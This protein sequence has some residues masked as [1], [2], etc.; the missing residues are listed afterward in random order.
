M[1]TVVGVG[2]EVAQQGL[3]ANREKNLDLKVSELA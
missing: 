3:V 1:R 2:C